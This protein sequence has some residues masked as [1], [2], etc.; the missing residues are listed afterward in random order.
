[1]AFEGTY[2]YTTSEISM[3]YSLT[4]KG[5]SFYEDKGIISPR[6]IDNGKYR[7][8]S[9][10]D[11]YHLYASKFF[12]NCGFS[13][14]E[15]AD[16]IQHKNLSDAENALHQ[17]THALRKKILYE[18]R[19]LT[20][21]ERILHVLDELPSLVDQ[22][23]VVTS[24]AFFRL[25]VRRYDLPHES[26]REDS[27]E[28]AHWNADIPI[29][30]AS[31]EYSLEELL[32]C[33]ERLSAGIG[34]IISAD[35]FDALGYRKS[36]RVAFLPSRLCVY[37]VIHGSP[38]TLYRP[39]RLLPCLGYLEEQGLRLSGNPFTRMLLVTNTPDG[40]IRYDEAW[41]PVEQAE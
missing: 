14:R 33:G 3:F 21:I 29:N 17:K 15:T 16:L 22:F 23:Q 28:F 40:P 30:V 13:L 26:T 5:L 24:P 41:F 6:R 2:R 1:M 39:D 32:S 10:T 20:H 38:E 31:L 36:D 35:D 4:G 34:N 11:C 18:E 8:F 7:E 12:S 25:F 27:Q 37:T 19:V 9:L